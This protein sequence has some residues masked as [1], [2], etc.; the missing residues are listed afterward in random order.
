[1]G[2][3]FDSVTTEME[4]GRR[5]SFP[6][7]VGAGR[8][9]RNTPRMGSN[10]LCA[11]RRSAPTDQPAKVRKRSIVTWQHHEKEEDRHAQ[12]RAGRPS[13]VTARRPAQTTRRPE[14]A[15]DRAS[16]RNELRRA[17][18]VPPEAPEHS[19]QREAWQRQRV[20]S[21]ERQRQSRRR[22]NGGADRAH[23]PARQERRPLLRLPRPAFSGG[24]K[25]LWTPL[26]NLSTSFW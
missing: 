8:A 1:M 23:R 24:D 15:E 21:R 4:F 18:R 6:R 19:L 2:L 16:R 9:S 25:H 11:V 20:R 7:G 3:K 5:V 12:D 22:A 13:A 17:D 26:L 14:R 10:L